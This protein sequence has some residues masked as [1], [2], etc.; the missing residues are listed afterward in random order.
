[1]S[2]TGQ[3]L[4]FQGHPEMDFLLSKMFLTLESPA[5]LSK[6]LDYGLKSIDSP[7]DG[8]LIFEKVM[9]WASGDLNL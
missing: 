2:K 5:S 8:K 7:H 4:T 9:R 6:K 1:M 3:V